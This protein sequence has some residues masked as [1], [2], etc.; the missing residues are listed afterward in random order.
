MKHKWISMFLSFSLLLSIFAGVMPQASAEEF[1]DVTQYSYTVMPIL[2]PF[3]YYLYVKTDNPDPSSFRLVDENSVFYGPEDHSSIM[4][5]QGNGHYISM[6]L[7]PGTYYI[8]RKIYPDVVM[9]MKQL[10][11]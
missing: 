8:S 3:C 2:S 6:E 11:G 1:P 9:K 10:S 4:I 5:N 7:A